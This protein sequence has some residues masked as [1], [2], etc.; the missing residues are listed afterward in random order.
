MSVAESGIFVKL[1]Y[2]GVPVLMKDKYRYFSSI[3]LDR[4]I[5]KYKM[6]FY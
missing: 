5:E 2:K 3:V 6:G 4:N 1:I